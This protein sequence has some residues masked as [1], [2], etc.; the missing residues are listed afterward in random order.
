[1]HNHYHASVYIDKE[2]ALALSD[3]QVIERWRCLYRLPT[4]V[5]R[6]Y[7]GEPLTKAE[8]SYVQTTLAEWRERLYDLG[9]F[10]KEVNLYIA[11]KANKEDGC[12]GHFWESRFKSQMLPDKKG[13]LC[14]MVY[15][16]L[17]PVRS[18]MADTPEKSQFISLQARIAEWRTGT[19]P[20][21]CLHPFMDTVDDQE[22]PHIPFNLIDYIELVD[23]T[24][25]QMRAEKRGYID[26]NLP[27]ILKRLNLSQSD[28]QQ[29]TTQ[30]ERP[31]ATVIGTK[32]NVKAISVQNGRT[33][34][35]GYSLPD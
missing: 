6:S 8:H 24:G 22:T 33:R 31:R 18:G 10:M 32:R 35:S 25:R 11:R 17:N 21:P 2:Q 13:L 16:E 28:W 14:A 23:W 12:T 29:A 4:L 20:L 34:A 1:M 7:A 30:L 27:P 26:N 3:H 15:D 19:R 5:K 9:W